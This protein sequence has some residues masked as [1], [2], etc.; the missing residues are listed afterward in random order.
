VGDDAGQDRVF[1][2]IGE[3]SRVEGVT[4]IHRNVTRVP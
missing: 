2:H 1:D 4:I 3:I